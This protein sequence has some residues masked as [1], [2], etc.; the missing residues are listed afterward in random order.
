MSEFE[1][2]D[3]EIAKVLPILQRLLWTDKETRLEL[4]RNGINVLPCNFYSST[5]SIE[6][7]EDSFEYKDS[8]HKD[9]GSPYSDTG[10]FDRDR[11]QAVLEG[12][13]P[14]AEDFAPPTDGDEEN[15]TGFF[16][17]NSQ[18]SYAD[19]MAYYCMIRQLKPS[20]VLEIGAGFSTLVAL[21][22][23]QRNG[24]GA[25]QCVEPYPRPFLEQ[26]S[27]V[28]LHRT[29]AQSLTPEFLNDTLSDGDV[30]FIDS[31]HTVKTGSD[32]LHIYLRLLPKLSRKV[33]VHVHD[34]FLPHGMPQSWL[35]E[36]QIFWTEQ[37]LLLA[38]LIDNPKAEFLYGSQVT[39]DCF[40]ELA[41]KLMRGRCAPGGGS[42]WF[43]YD[44]RTKR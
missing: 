40:P 12:L 28:T 30:L 14:H 36:Q 38:L 17:K 32:C 21:D 43:T 8:E 39:L 10:I 29:K 31:T 42:V 18:F 23:V 44:G 15:C 11:I 35:L 5:P 41:G 20:T 25:V 37:Y 22:A 9:T 1:V 2:S 24:D 33:W 26:D 3:K 19:A 16:W 13:L 7:I 6:E 27:R 34:V 4:Q